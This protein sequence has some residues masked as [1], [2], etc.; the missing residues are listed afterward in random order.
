MA[1]KTGKKT[2]V[3]LMGLPFHGKSQLMDQVG[4]LLPLYYVNKDNFT[5]RRELC[6]VFDFPLHNTA[7]FQDILR[8]RSE[9]NYTDVLCERLE[10]V[11]Q[12]IVDSAPLELIDLYTKAYAQVRYISAYAY[13]RCHEEMIQSMRKRDELDEKCGVEPIYIYVIWP[14]DEC[15]RE[16]STRQTLVMDE[17]VFTNLHYLLLMHQEMN[18]ARKNILIDFTNDASTY[19]KNIADMVEFVLSNVPREI[20][21]ASNLI[22]MAKNIKMIRK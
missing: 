21:L 11:N 12:V 18:N 19:K 5:D 9:E 14:S 8:R 20:F 1:E 6:K 3:R 22:H 7:V 15:V 10:I 13:E 16:M 4:S 17:S 2:V